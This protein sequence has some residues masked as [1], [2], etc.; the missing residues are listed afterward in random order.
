MVWRLTAAKEKRC[1]PDDL[2][3][4]NGKTCPIGE[5]NE[6]K[7]I[8]AGEFN[9]DAGCSDL[10]H[11]VTHSDPHDRR[12]AVLRYRAAFSSAEESVM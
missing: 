12:S 9:S 6:G 8:V 10:P 3:S 4:L 1:L 5:I 11:G 2:S 7:T